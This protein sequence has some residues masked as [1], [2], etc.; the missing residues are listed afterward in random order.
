MTLA[1]WT[2]A[3]RSEPTHPTTE[4]GAVSLCISPSHPGYNDLFTLADFRVGSSGG[5]VIWLV[6]RDTD[7]IKAQKAAAK[8]HRAAELIGEAREEIE[9]INADDPADTHA[10][11]AQ[12]Q[13][14]VRSEARILSKW[15]E[16]APV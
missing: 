3:H 8:L 13:A 15:A 10:D 12:Y 7:P 11:L 5:G 2:K 9:F 6:P 4:T 1:E 14:G 16:S